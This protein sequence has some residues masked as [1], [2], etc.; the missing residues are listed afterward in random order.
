MFDQDKRMKM[1]HKYIM[2]EDDESSQVWMIDS[3]GKENE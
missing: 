1:K 2:I 3:S